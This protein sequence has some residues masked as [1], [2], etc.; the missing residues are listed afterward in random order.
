M[1]NSFVVTVGQTSAGHGG[2]FSPEIM[3]AAATLYYEQDATQAQV[4]A[5]L[6]T[7]R[8]TVSRILSEA[9]RRG[10]VRI[11]VIPPGEPDHADTARRVA[12]ALGLRKVWVTP[13]ALGQPVGTALAPALSE[14]LVEQG[15][16]PGEVL[17]MSSGRTVYEA[18]QADLP[19]L[20]GVR[21]APTVGGHEDPAPWYATNEIVRMVA[22]KVGGTPTFLYAP[23]LP[24]RELY[25]HLLEDPSFARVVQMWRQARCAV[26]G[27]GAPPSGRTSLAATVPREAPVLRSAV[28][29][30]CTR[31]Y[32]SEGHAMPFPGW[33]RLVAIDHDTLRAIP[34]CIAV[35]AGADKVA[36]LAAGA[37]AGWFSHL[38]T[39]APT[40][41]A[42]LTMTGAG[43]T[44][45]QVREM[46]ESTTSPRTPGHSRPE[47]R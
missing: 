16:Q 18:A 30:V 37:R 17:L 10:M 8:A 28:G 31:F 43:V 4:A 7:S 25:E 2:G 29:D 38:V 1:T 46:I 42:L 26:V 12:D 39:D 6:G 13:P 45:Q 40:A 11:E 36:A 23:A 24:G 33:E 27:V 44:E 14:A 34:T 22:A 32:D 19:T 3:Y 9:R 21:I 15:L 35:A 20:P 41:L 47:G 5:R